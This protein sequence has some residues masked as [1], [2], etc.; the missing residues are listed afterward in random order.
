MARLQELAE[1]SIR[2]LEQNARHLEAL[3]AFYASLLQ[4]EQEEHVEK[5]EATVH[6]FDD[7]RRKRKRDI[8]PTS[9]SN[10][11]NTTNTSNVRKQARSTSGKRVQS[12]LM[13]KSGP[14]NTG[15]YCG[16]CE[17]MRKQTPRPHMHKH[18][19]DTCPSLHTQH[20][21]S[22]DG[23][24]FLLGCGYC[25]STGPFQRYRGDAFFGDTR[26]A[27]H[28]VD[29]HC[30]E[31]PCHKLVWDTNNAINNVLTSRVFADEYDRLREEK[32]KH[33]SSV[34]LTWQTYTLERLGGRVMAAGGDID[35]AGMMDV[36][37]REIGKMLEAA[38]APIRDST[39]ISY[40]DFSSSAM[41]GPLSGA[42][43]AIG[44]LQDNEELFDFEMVSSDSF[45][46]AL[47]PH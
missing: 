25:T 30:P 20:Q 45:V 2:V 10:P 5:A 41:T 16:I 29:A 44:V 1:D 34:C 37:R 15:Y 24:Q 11:N 13:S 47:R 42:S 18:L 28:V 22:T 26:L 23:E 12:A 38:Y 4:D 9:D 3:K 21:T 17:K 36:V 32:Y 39:Q 8:S 7:S 6:K 14:S 33:L 43:F 27:Q 19:L 31:H 35:S 46:G 40:A